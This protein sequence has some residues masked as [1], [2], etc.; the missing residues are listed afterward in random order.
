LTDAQKLKL[1]V[2]AMLDGLMEKFEIHSHGN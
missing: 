1:H 2:D